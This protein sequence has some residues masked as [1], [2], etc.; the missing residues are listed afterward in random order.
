MNFENIILN[1]IRCSIDSTFCNRLKNKSINKLH[2]NT[3]M[4][5]Y[6]KDNKY[7]LWL[8]SNH[9]NSNII[10]LWIVLKN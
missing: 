10:A 5:E 9:A 3:C 4:D 7:G 2:E 1:F 6:Q 8:G